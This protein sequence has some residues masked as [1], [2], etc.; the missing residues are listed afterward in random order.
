MGYSPDTVSRPIHFVK[1]FQV[2]QKNN[3]LNDEHIVRNMYFMYEGH[4]SCTSLQEAAQ[5]D[6]S[7]EPTIFTS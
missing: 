6:S 2:N 3:T 5:L 7:T 4:S 1:K